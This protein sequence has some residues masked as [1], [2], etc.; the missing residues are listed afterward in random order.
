M[1]MYHI[2]FFAPREIREAC[3][4]IRKSDHHI[5]LHLNLYVKKTAYHVFG[6]NRDTL[7]EF[8]RKAGCYPKQFSVIDTHG[9][10]VRYGHTIYH[11]DDWRRNV[12]QRYQEL[13][14]RL[15]EES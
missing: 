10:C 9:T 13:I 7:I 4:W 3:E 11:F 15:E 8:G 5:A 2:K 12:T 1:M 14:N 6:S